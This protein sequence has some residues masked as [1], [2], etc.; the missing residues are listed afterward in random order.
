MT[1][2]LEFTVVVRVGGSSTTRSK[3]SGVIF[4]CFF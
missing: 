2:S 4:F 3:D 1:S